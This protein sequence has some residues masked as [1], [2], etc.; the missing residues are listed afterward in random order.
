[1]ACRPVWYNLILT[2]APSQTVTG[3]RFYKSA[4]VREL[5]RDSFE[6]CLDER[7]IETP[8]G[9]KLAVPARAL[10]EAIAEEWNRQGDVISPQKLP[11][12]RLANSAID[13][14]AGNECQVIEDILKYASTDLLCYRASHPESLMTGQAK[15]W[16]PILDWIRTEYDADFAVT[17]GLAPVTQPAAAMDAIKAALMAFSAFEL[18][19]VHVMTTLTGS[20]LIALA[21][22][23]GRLD[24]SASWK[25]AHADEDWQISRWG[26]DFEAKERRMNRYLEFENASRFLHLSQ[27]IE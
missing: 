20:A 6:I 8:A 19:A 13:G 4:S 26:E 17:S 21:H 10:A 11:L 12:T 14:V 23:R 15:L 7:P 24:L 9:H 3:K 2:M 27:C 16:D 1:L 5:S 22:A 25:A 18:A